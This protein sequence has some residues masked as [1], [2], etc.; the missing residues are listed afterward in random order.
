MYI[1]PSD[2]NTVM[3]DNDFRYF[4][5]LEGII[6]SVDSESELGVMSKDKVHNIRIIPSNGEKLSL[7]ISEIIKFHRHLGI[8]ID[9]SKSIKAS[10][11]I[12]YKIE[13]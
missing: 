13:I 4:T 8:F 3:P 5:L 11:R 6:N 10:K 1:K 7:I 2:L 12:F 9:L